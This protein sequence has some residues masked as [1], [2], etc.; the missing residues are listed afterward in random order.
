MN[1]VIYKGADSSFKITGI[2]FPKN[3]EV[4]LTDDQLK[5][6]KDDKFGKQFIENKTFVIS[7]KAED[8]PKTAEKTVAA[9]DSHA[10]TEA[11]K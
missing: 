6:L 8:K 7:K 9:K 1:K 3:K 5:A 4:D 11:K 2:L 10:S